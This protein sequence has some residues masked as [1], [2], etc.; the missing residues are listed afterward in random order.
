MS[1]IQA[2]AQKAAA[3]LR[4]EVANKYSEAS[5]I[6]DLNSRIKELESE[7]L[8]S[9]PQQK[10][11]GVAHWLDHHDML[12]EADRVRAMYAATVPEVGE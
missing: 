12:E 6:A 8:A 10:A 11:Q 3:R 9:S 7:R 1:D 2:M 4:R 5:L